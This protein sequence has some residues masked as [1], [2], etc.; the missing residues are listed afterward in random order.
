MVAYERRSVAV[1]RV[2]AAAAFPPMRPKFMKDSMRM[3]L[4]AARPLASTALRH[5]VGHGERFLTPKRRGRFS[6]QRPGQLHTTCRPQQHEQSRSRFKVP[7]RVDRFAPVSDLQF[8][9]RRAHDTSLSRGLLVALSVL[10]A[11]LLSFTTWLREESRVP[12]VILVCCLVR[13]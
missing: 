6:R 10:L 8:S 2:G 5:F 13:R 4:A 1:G 11:M 12:R 3:T 9:S 7:V